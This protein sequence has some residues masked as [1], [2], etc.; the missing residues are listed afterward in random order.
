MGVALGLRAAAWASEEDQMTKE[1]NA[2]RSNRVLSQLESLAVRLEVVVGYWERRV[3][4][5]L[6]PAQEGEVGDLDAEAVK[7]Q[8]AALSESMDRRVFEAEQLA[9]RVNSGEVTDEEREEYLGRWKRG[10][11]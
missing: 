10:P 11:G 6:E 7:K 3:A 5:E 9:A 8:E 1:T 2:F 4:A